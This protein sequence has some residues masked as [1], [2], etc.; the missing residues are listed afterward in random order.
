MA[1]NIC[2]WRNS[3]VRTLICYCA[4]KDITWKLTSRMLPPRVRGGSIRFS[5]L[6][7]YG[8]KE[9]R[10]IG[11]ENRN[12]SVLIC[13]T[14]ASLQS[15]FHLRHTQTDTQNRRLYAE[16]C[17]TFSQNNSNFKIPNYSTISGCIRTIFWLDRPAKEA[18]ISHYSLEGF[19]TNLHRDTRGANIQRHN[20]TQHNTHAHRQALRNVSQNETWLK[21]NYIITW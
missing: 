13:S 5:Q 8:D 18:P 1:Q 6:H 2:N 15:S 19:P 12:M 9:R 11:W 21:G 16:I 14:A 10:P 3:G 20:T 7:V 17:S 4:T